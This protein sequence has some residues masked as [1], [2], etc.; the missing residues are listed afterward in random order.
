MQINCTQEE[1]REVQTV[2]LLDW[3]ITC[4][5]AGAFRGSMAPATKTRVRRYGR[6]GE[7]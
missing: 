5:L 6:F 1:I 2:L 3:S 7:I 4:R